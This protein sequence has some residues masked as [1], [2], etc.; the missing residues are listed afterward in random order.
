[1]EVF[2]LVTHNTWDTRKIKQMSTGC[3]VC[4]LS[5]ILVALA[6]PSKL[7]LDPTASSTYPLPDS[8][9]VL[10]M[11]PFPTL[12]EAWDAYYNL[13]ASSLQKK[14]GMNIPQSLDWTEDL[15]AS[16]T[17]PRLALGQTCGWPLTTR[18]KK[19]VKVLGTFSFDS[20]FDPSYMYRSVIVSRIGE[21]FEKLKYSRAAVNSMGSL[22][23]YISLLDAFDV[24][25]WEGTISVTGGHATS[26]QRI[27][28]GDADVASIDAITWDYLRRDYNSS[29][30]G[31]Q[32]VGHGPFVPCLPLIISGEAS[33]SDVAAWRSAFYGAVNDTRAKP[34]L[35]K[36]MIRGFQAL[37]LADYEK[38]LSS[39]LEKYNS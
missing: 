1:V 11:Y 30:H 37:D 5:F 15:E 10:G 14:L 27:Q 13:L 20:A 3:S 25:R 7:V 36:L 21:D 18:L 31:L 39:L 4:L 12:T 28:S 35:E 26:L 22:S 29:L 8:F 19:H 23:G 38:S 24:L 34:F 6:S 17:D 33:D 16:W 32:V 9:A 2:L